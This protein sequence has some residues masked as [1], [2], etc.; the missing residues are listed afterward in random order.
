MKNLRRIVIAVLIIV[1]FVQILFLASV[2]ADDWTQTSQSD[3]DAGIKNNVDT[4]SDSGNVTLFQVWNKYPTRYVLDVGPSPWD[5]THVYSPSVLYDGIIYRM[6]Y[7]GSAGTTYQIGYA[8]SNDGISWTK[9]VSNPVLSA[10]PL[11][12]WDCDRVY[13]PTVLFI[14][15]NYHMW[16][17]GD[18]GTTDRI[19]YAISSDGAT[20]IKNISNPVLDIGSAGAWDDDDIRTP[21]VIFDGTTYH[22]WY[23]GYD[24]SNWRIGYANSTDGITWMKYTSNPVLNL[25][26]SGSWDS[27]SV[28]YPT[29][30]YDGITYHMW[31]SG[32]DGINVRIGYAT[33]LDGIAWTKHQ[34]NPVLDIGP[35]NTWDDDMIW[36]PTIIQD[37]G[38]YKMW[39]GGKDSTTYRIGYAT[40]P[41]GITWTKIPTIPVLDIGLPGSWEDFFAYEPAVIFDGTTYHMWYS[42]HNG[43]NARIGYATSPDGITWTKNPANPVLGLG[44]PG[45]WDDAYVNSP[46]VFYDG[47]TYHMWYSGHDI[48][49]ARIGYA[50]SLDGITWTKDPTNPVLGLGPPGSWD[51]VHVTSS[52]VLYDGITYHMWYSG[53]DGVNYRIGYATSP[54]GVSWTKYATNPV[55]DLDSPGSWD[56]EWVYD[57]TVF[58]DGTTY[59]MW[60]GGYDGTNARIGYASSSDGISWTKSVSNPVLDIGPSNSWDD[61]HVEDPMVLYLGETYHMWFTGDDG[62]NARIG[63]ATFGYPPSGSLTSSVFDSGAPGTIWNFI[64]WTEYLPPGTNITLATRSGNTPIPDISWSPWSVEMWDETGSSIISPRSRCIQYRATLTTTNKTLTPILSEVNINYVLNTAQPPTLLSPTNDTLTSDNTP[65]FAWNFNDLEGDSQTGFTVQI[66]NDSSFISI[67]YTSGDVSSSS[68]LWTPSA[69]IS[70]GLWY[71]RVRTKDTYD[72][73]SGYSNYWIIKIDT[74]P[75]TI[76]DVTAVPNPQEVF[77][78][79]NISANVTD[80]YQLFGVWVEIYDPNG[81]FVGNFSML[82]DS[83]NGR[84]YLNQTYGIAGT[85]TFTIWAN[86]TSD[87]WAKGEGTFV[88]ER[89]AYNWK[90]IIALIFALILLLIGILVSYKRPIKFTGILGRDRLYTFLGGVLPFVIAEI[91]TGIISLITG[92]LSVPPILGVGLV[93]DLIILIIGIISCIVIS[94]KG[95]IPKSYEEGAQPMPPPPPGSS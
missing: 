70:D 8:T 45:S 57:P 15:G 3:F 81:N 23:S 9:S 65:T 29:V 27:A 21:V 88:M 38:V 82:Y 69:P 11:P 62:P 33:S 12:A 47:A 14:G 44:L 79:V 90:P 54:D 87:N 63:Y 83:V 85:Y 50:T 4:I 94:V 19:G 37:G 26:P 75:P 58:Y 16:Y 53:Y 84:Y 80:N 60:F 42:G 55:L 74:T 78:D 2:Q 36:F 56:D 71:W 66:D 68:E 92:L 49:N 95:T 28:Y 76:T 40:S 18:D 13:F 20:W 39:Y 43:L 24:I 10:D 6:W 46:S 17:T 93:V 89:E 48:F 52:T 72:L 32:A 59:H 86:D 41:D 5:N 64:N 91:I 73:W 77:G 67:D 61:V 22:M 25:G 31:Y 30:I 35:S 51:D 7:S 1:F 34:T